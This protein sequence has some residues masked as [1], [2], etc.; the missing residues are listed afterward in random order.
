MEFE[1]RI[2]ELEAKV[3]QL[4]GLLQ[5]RELLDNTP[6]VATRV[7]VPGAGEPEVVQPQHSSRRGML[8]LAGAAAAGVVVST[9]AS[10]RPAAATTDEN[11]VTGHINHATQQT[12]LIYGGA[13]NTTKGPDL[14]SGTPMLD[15]NAS[16]SPGADKIAI[17][18]TGT[19]PIQVIASGTAGVQSLGGEF[20]LASYLTSKANIFLSPN[21]DFIFAGPKTLPRLRTDSHLVGEIDNVAGDLWMCVEAGTPGT[22][23]KITGPAAAGAFHAISPARVYDS[24]SAAPTPGQLGSGANRLVSVADQ[25]NLNTGAVATANVVPVGASAVSVNVTIANTVDGGYLAVNPGGNTVVSASAIN[26]TA[27]G[28][29]A[30]NSIIVP[31]NAARQ[32]TVICGGG[33]TDFILDV[34]GYFL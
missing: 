26:W 28:Q 34:S 33:S 8:R 1:Q 16:L 27:S 20:S 23:R 29:A 15:V 10:A 31:I 5:Q 14:T 18:A 22:W 11:V 30:A 25:R 19:T 12:R 24:R 2:A 21:N 13:I 32:V 17:Q 4:T 7:A 6:A 9:V 3:E